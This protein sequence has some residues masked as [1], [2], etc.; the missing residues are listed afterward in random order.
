MRNLRLNL[1]RQ[2]HMVSQW[3][4]WGF[5]RPLLLIMFYCLSGPPELLAELHGDAF[6]SV[7]DSKNIVI[8]Q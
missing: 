7:G 4:S 5:S 1:C 6:F 8:D 3:L 2:D